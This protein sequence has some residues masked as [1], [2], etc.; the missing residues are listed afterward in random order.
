MHAIDYEIDE[1]IKAH[2]ACGKIAVVVRG[3]L[4]GC[5][6]CVESVRDDGVV[7]LRSSNHIPSTVYPSQNDVLL[8]TQVVYVSF[9]SNNLHICRVSAYSAISGH[10]FSVQYSKIRI[11]KDKNCMKEILTVEGSSPF[12]TASD[13]PVEIFDVRYT[14][15]LLQRLF[16]Y[17]LGSFH[18]HKRSS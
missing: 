14:L 11:M 4:K 5:L 6:G 9:Y 12:K 7:V 1:P 17:I 15:L 2:F 8:P 16:I 3:L 18:V 10:S 13:L